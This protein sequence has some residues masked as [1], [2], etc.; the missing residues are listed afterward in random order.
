MEYW[1]T[2]LV[3]EYMEMPQTHALVPET[4][5]AGRPVN[6]ATHLITVIG[7]NFTNDTECYIDEVLTKTRW[8]AQNLIECHVPAIHRAGEISNVKFMQRSW[9]V[10]RK[11][12]LNITYVA[13]PYVYLVE[14]S[15]IFTG[16]VSQ[17]LT[18]HIVDI[19]AYDNSTMGTKQLGSYYCK[20]GSI[21]VKA[22][23][24][25]TIDDYSQD[26][27]PT[28]VKAV[29]PPTARRQ[30]QC[31]CPQLTQSQVVQVEIMTPRGTTFSRESANS[32]LEYINRPT[33]TKTEPA[34]I[35]MLEISDD[36]RQLFIDVT[37][38]DFY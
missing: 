9:Y 18:V 20:F 36:S 38:S 10:S 13:Q 30:I 28:H 19:E 7:S 6:R 27:L 21:S 17:L 1:D 11:P 14:P 2:N 12:G 8:L 23:A 22:T 26:R 29:M 25:R 31:R 37:G 24:V 4:L 5:P 16:R 33:M 35:P 34:I 3:L 15:I 32:T